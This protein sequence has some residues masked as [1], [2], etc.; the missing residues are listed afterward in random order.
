MDMPFATTIPHRFLLFNWRPR[1]ER[2]QR[3]ES[4]RW[5]GGGLSMARPWLGAW[6]RVDVWCWADGGLGAEWNGIWEALLTKSARVSRFDLTCDQGQKYQHIFSTQ[7]NNMW[8]LVLDY[9][10]GFS[11]CAVSSSPLP[12]HCYC[13]WL[14]IHITI[15]GKWRRMPLLFIIRKVLNT[16]SSFNVGSDR[17]SRCHSDFR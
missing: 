8:V 5:W 16:I 9:R 4:H 1:Y 15:V 12:N 6:F 17:V 2:S 3:L 14:Y 11:C 7:F 10:N 13:L